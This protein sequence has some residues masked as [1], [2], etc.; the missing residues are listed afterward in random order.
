MTT[1]RQPASEQLRACAVC[2]CIQRLA[3]D[4]PSGYQWRC[5]R[6]SSHL[7]DHRPARYPGL[8]A[9]CALAALI[10]YPV[11]VSA[12]V[13]RLER[14]G[15]AHESSILGGSIALLEH[16]EWLVG[17]VVLGCSVVLPLAKLIAI[18]ILERGLLAERR[19][20]AWVYRMVEITGRWGMVDVLLVA[21]LVAAVKLGDLVTVT[22]G[23][24]IL[25]FTLV[26]ILSLVAA[27]TFDHHRLWGDRP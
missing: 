21:I 4:C 12:P 8:A 17:C 25:A 19:H 22:P 13:M 10:L 16:G 1:S 27:A 20:R 14:L 2:G 18:L 24:G 26:V 23:P 7:Y 5:C 11:A 6:C 9:A 3:A 15:H